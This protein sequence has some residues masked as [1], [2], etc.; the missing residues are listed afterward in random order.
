[1]SLVN[2]RIGCKTE[3]IIEKLG[4][5][6]VPQLPHGHTLSCAKTLKVHGRFHPHCRA[7]PSGRDT[8]ESISH[9]ATSH[10]VE[11]SYLAPHSDET[12][13][14][15]MGGTRNWEERVGEFS[16]CGHL[17]ARE[18]AVRVCGCVGVLTA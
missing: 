8:Y 5:F 12:E 11:A 10:W 13:A 2:N 1:M 14:S 9:I 4:R 17:R 16:E 18:A 3:S 6:V 15:D 7:F